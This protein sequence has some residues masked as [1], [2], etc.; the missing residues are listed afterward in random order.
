MQPRA[1]LVIDVCRGAQ[2]QVMGELV[3]RWLDDLL[4]AS[5]WVLAPECDREHQGRV[6]AVQIDAGIQA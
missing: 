6:L 5:R 2:F 4:P 1:D 3:R